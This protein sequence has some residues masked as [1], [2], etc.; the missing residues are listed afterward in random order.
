MST[1]SLGSYV[2]IYFL[3]IFLTE[4]TLLIYG[5]YMMVVP[6]TVRWIYPKYN[7]LKGLD[8]NI[9]T[10]YTLLRI[11]TIP[12]KVLQRIICWFISEV[13]MLDNS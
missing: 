1:I 8:R 2:Y 7:Y 3:N 13:G 11:Y 6:L 4:T 9:L 5:V 12:R 10:V